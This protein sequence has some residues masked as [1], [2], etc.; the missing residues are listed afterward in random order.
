M[1]SYTRRKAG[2]KT[3]YSFSITVTTAHFNLFVS[4][5]FK[6]KRVFPTH[7]LLFLSEILSAFLPEMILVIRAEGM[8]KLSLVFTALGHIEVDGSTF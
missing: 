3:L 8:V 7:F 5:R 4:F 2:N 6:N 1:F